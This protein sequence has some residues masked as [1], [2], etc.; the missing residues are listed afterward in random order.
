MKKNILIVS[1]GILLIFLISC[2]SDE[3]TT[4][5]DGTPDGDADSSIDGDTDPD[6]ESNEAEGDSADEDTSQDGDS[7][8]EVEIDEGDVDEFDGDGDA[9]TDADAELDQEPDTVD[10]ESSSDLDVEI[11]GAEASDAEHDNSLETDSETDR[12]F[13]QYILAAVE[14]AYTNYGLLGYDSA[15]LT[16]DI[17]YGSYGWIYATGGSRTMSVSAMMEVILTAM[18]LYSDDTGD[19]SV[20]DYLPKSSW[21]DLGVTNI[22]SW[23]WVNP[24]LGSAGTA[25]TLVAFGMGELVSFEDLKPGSFINFNRINGTSHAVVFL[26]FINAEGTVFDTYSEDA[27]GFYYFSAQ[28]QYEVGL[29]GLDYRYGLFNA[30][31]YPTMPYKRD[32]NII[33]S[34]DQKIFNAGVMLHP[35]FWSGAH[36]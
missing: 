30:D 10:L 32:L 12:Y 20:W 31:T 11:E 2:G 5:S 8:R 29:G 34:S 27:I 13:N 15:E 24:D 28:G 36:P 22:K 26:G 25:D 19:Q 9:D 35:D 7:E 1:A 14:S 4:D 18:Q 3:S 6:L 21:E 17:A 33:R 16:H 23:L